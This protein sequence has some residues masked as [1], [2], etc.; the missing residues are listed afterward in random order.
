MSVDANFEP[1]PFAEWVDRIITEAETLTDPDG[2][3]LHVGRSRIQGP[4]KVSFA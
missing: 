2:D 3:P 1:D 4:C